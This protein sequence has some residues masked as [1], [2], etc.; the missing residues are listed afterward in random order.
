[1]SVSSAISEFK[2]NL[3]PHVTLI[4]VSKT[5]PNEL[6]LDAYHGGQRDF[7]ENKV[8]ELVPKFESLPRDIRWHLIGHLQS[9]KVKYIA[10]FVYM[11]HSIDS[12]KLLEEVNKQALKCGRVI[13]VLLQIFVAQEETKFGFSFE[14]ARTLLIAYNNKTFPGV[15]ID[16]IMGMATNTDDM[17]QVRNEF[18]SLRQF[19]EEIQTSNPEMKV[20]SMGMSSDWQIAVEEGST[21]IRIGST[22]FGSR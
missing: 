13:P 16:G 6:I 12:I 19:A 3:P 20:I 11:I 18:S 2:I 15:R 22:L 10:P 17:N 5:K 7:G 1:M 14:E 4:A 9:N 8:Q 21:M